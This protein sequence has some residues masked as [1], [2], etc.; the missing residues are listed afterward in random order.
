MRE[1]LDKT[2]RFGKRHGMQMFERNDD[3]MDLLMVHK[4][5]DRVMTRR[6]AL[7]KMGAGSMALALAG[8]VVAGSARQAAAQDEVSAAAA[9][10]FRTTS[11]LNL[12]AEPSTSAKVLTVI[13]Y[14]GAVQAVGPEQNGFLK[15]S[16]QGTIG[17]AYSAY[18]TVTNGGSNDVP[19]PV[20]FGYTTDAVN[21]RSGP[22][23]GYSVIRVLPAGTKIELFD[24]YQNNYRYVGYAAQPGWVYLDYISTNGGGQPSTNKTTTAALNMRSQPTTTAS[25]IMVVPAGASVRIGDQVS[26]GYRQVTYNSRTGWVLNDYLR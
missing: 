16:Y 15:V 20:G 23:T 22:G 10:W 2:M 6:E 25:I 18:L 17:W 8:L 26:N 13:P 19:V 21:F 5:D 9:G 3:E 4:L 1:G 14:D 24:S 12:R 7:R 11:A